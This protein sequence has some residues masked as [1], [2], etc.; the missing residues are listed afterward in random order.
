MTILMAILIILMA[1]RA[2]SDNY[3]H[4]PEDH[5]GHLEGQPGHRDDYPGGPGHPEDLSDHEHKTKWE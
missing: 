5:P 1:M 3:L 2:I 4:H